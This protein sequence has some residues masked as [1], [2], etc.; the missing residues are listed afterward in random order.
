MGFDLYGLSPKNPDNLVSPEMNWGNPSITEEDKKEHFKAVD[1]YQE[2][3]PGNYFRANVW[4]WRPLWD[5]TA[6]NCDDILTSKDIEAGSVN[7]MHK[8]SKTKANK[9]AK[10]LKETLKDGTADSYETRIMERQEL[11]IEA[12][13]IVDKGLNKLAEIVK[14]ETGKED[15]V[16]RDYPNKYKE[17]W[18]KIYA[19]RTM[20]S[21]YPFK[22]SFLKQF[23]SFCED[24]GGFEIG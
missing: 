13:A 11:S 21:S 24:S 12:N 23:I 15:I 9:I 14:K 19:T 18:E 10:R 4:W 6:N 3:V 16:P 8:I 2:A 22:V 7:D 5:F 1:K 20:A 17:A